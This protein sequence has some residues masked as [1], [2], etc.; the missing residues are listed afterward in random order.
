[1]V[2]QADF[3]E[4]GSFQT[5]RS[6]EI[7]EKSILVVA[8]DLHS[9]IQVAS[10]K[11]VGLVFN[12]VELQLLQLSQMVCGESSKVDHISMDIIYQG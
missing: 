10:Q 6:L 12:K 5:F 11:V 8:Q 3:K 2:L 7:L 9:F 1:M 4:V